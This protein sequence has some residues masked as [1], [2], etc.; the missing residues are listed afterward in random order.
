M[1][2]VRRGGIRR[3]HTRRDFGVYCGRRCRCWSVVIGTIVLP[4]SGTCDTLLSIIL[5]LLQVI[6]VV[7]NAENG[8]RVHVKKKKSDLH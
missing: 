6:H 3:S 4:L 5:V 2:D 7:V 1:V 8:A